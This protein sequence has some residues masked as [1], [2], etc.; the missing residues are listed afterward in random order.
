VRRRC[1]PNKG[2]N[3]SFSDFSRTSKPHSRDPL[4]ISE[5]IVSEAKRKPLYQPWNEEA[6]RADLH[7]G[8]M[9]PT[10]RW[11]YRTLL[12]AAFFH[13]TRPYLPDDDAQLWLLAGCESPKQWERNKDVVRV[14][15][16]PV[17]V[18][19]ERLLSQKRLLADW[20]RIEEK[21]EALAEAGR[22]GGKANAK[23]EP[24]KCLPDA[25]GGVANT[26]QEK[27]R[28]VEVKEREEKKNQ[29]RVALAGDGMTPDVVLS[30]WQQERGVLPGVRDL[31]P[32]RVRKIKARLARGNPKEFLEKFR[33][34]VQKAAASS[35]CV[36]GGWMSFD[37]LIDNGTNMAKVLEGQYDD[38]RRTGTG[39]GMN[40]DASVGKY[41]PSRDRAQTP[42]E[43]AEMERQQIEIER[44][45][46]LEK[47]TLPVNAGTVAWATE[48]RDRLKKIPK[49]PAQ[50]PRPLW[51]KNFLNSAAPEQVPA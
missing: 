48:K 43:T 27:L 34:A 32:E 39:A 21:R 38:S 3:D 12:Q 24:S 35:F 49:L 18:G 19:G 37:W 45:D 17:E 9:A 31:T 6:F 29:P 30:I 23:P 16:T 51:L 8:A 41:D 20:N 50:D 1:S 7:V 15:F 25:K 13:S 46:G 36:G 5:Q 33:L 26:N 42:E 40:R 10:Q 14:M 11:M 4:R 47:G 22:K 28:E 44:W 2:P